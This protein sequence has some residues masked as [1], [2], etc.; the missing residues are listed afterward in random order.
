MSIW[1]LQQLIVGMCC[2]AG[3]CSHGQLQPMVDKSHDCFDRGGEPHLNNEGIAHLHS[4]SCVAV[5]QLLCVQE[6]SD[7]S[8]SPG[9][10]LHQGLLVSLVGLVDMLQAFLQS[11]QHCMIASGIRMA[12][13][14]GLDWMM[15]CTGLA[16]GQV[17]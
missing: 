4:R 1:V 10:G 3:V 9:Q 6:G 8:S 12:H 2:Q 15:Y 13:N 17:C 16:N 14:S 11:L 5:K 7:G